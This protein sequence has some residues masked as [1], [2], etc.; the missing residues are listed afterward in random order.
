[1]IPDNQ[2]IDLGTVYHHIKIPTFPIPPLEIFFGEASSREWPEEL[3]EYIPVNIMGVN[4][5]LFKIDSR[6]GTY[7]VVAPEDSFVRS[8]HWISMRQKGPYGCAIIVGGVSN[9]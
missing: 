2:S 5:E 8:T 3:H 7:T 1:M 4:L 6:R 9:G